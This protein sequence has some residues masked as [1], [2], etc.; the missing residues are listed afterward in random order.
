MTNQEEKLIDAATWAGRQQAF[1]VVVSKCTLAQA[2]CLRQ[3]R[4][5]RAYEQYGLTWDEFCPH[6]AGISRSKADHLIQQV[7]EFGE[8]YFRLSALVNISDETY[9]AV[10]PL[11]HGETINLGG[12]KLALIPENATKIRAAI[13]SFREELHKTHIETLQQRGNMMDLHKQLGEIVENFSRRARHPLPTDEVGKL[14]ALLNY[15]IRQLNEVKKQFNCP[16]V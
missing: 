1:A 13:Q 3:M 14:P 12:E 7:K 8:D 11:L 16:A 9:R 15:A 4:E 2:E 6:H 5:T 10:A